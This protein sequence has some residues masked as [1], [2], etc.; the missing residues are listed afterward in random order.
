MAAYG[1]LTG[2]LILGYF[3]RGL[4]LLVPITVI[5]WAIYRVLAFLSLI[6]I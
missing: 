2:R 3:L 5:V 6:H 1:R 4:L